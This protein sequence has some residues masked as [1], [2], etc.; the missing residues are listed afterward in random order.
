MAIT[1]SGRVIYVINELNCTVTAFHR[2]PT[3]GA[4]TEFQSLSTLPPGVAQQKDYSTAEL[5]LSPTGAFLYGSN[6]G[7]NSLTVYSVDKASGRLTY[8]ANTPTNGKTPRGFGIEPGGGYLIAGNQESDSVVV[9]KIDRL[10][11]KLTPGATIKV[12]APVDVKFVA[13]R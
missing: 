9:F 12:G 5:E 3:T 1:A 7:H 10:T 6:R 2:D 8:V 11:G 4:L 13:A